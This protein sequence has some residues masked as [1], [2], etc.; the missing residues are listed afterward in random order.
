MSGF[1]PQTPLL[2]VMSP[3]LVFH[4]LPATASSLTPTDPVQQTVHFYII[5]YDSPAQKI[6]QGEPSNASVS[7]LVRNRSAQ[8]GAI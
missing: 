7:Y 3:Q 5:N 1:L 2:S 8:E 6:G 4:A